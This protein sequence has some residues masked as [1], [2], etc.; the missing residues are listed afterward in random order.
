MK[1]KIVVPQKIDKPYT[2]WQVN[3]PAAM[4]GTR[5]VRKFFATK[6]EADSFI[7]RTLSR[8]WDGAEV[9]PRARAGGPEDSH[10][11]EGMRIDELIHVYLSRQESR[12]GKT[13]MRQL[14]YIFKSL[15]KSMGN[16]TVKKVTH[17][18]IDDWLNTIPEGSTRWN[19][20]RIARRL[21]EHAINWLEVVE[22]N[23]LK[24]I[25]PPP[26]SSAEGGKGIDVL[27]PEQMSSCIKEA[28]AFPE[29]ERTRLLAWLALGGFAGLRT[30]EILNS[31]W[32]DVDL[33]AGEIYVRQPKRVRGWHP[34]YVKILP[35]ARRLFEKCNRP[36]ALELDTNA[37]TRADA[38][39]HGEG[40]RF[41]LN[42]QKILPGGQRTLYLLRRELM[43]RMGWKKWPQNCLRH[44]YGTYHLA[45]WE[46]LAKLRGQMGHESEGITRRHYATAA[47]GV[48]AAA[49]WAIGP[50][51]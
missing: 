48:D 8:G 50:K 47:R 26:K 7:A 32:Q 1:S 5:R 43:N 24:R 40:G 20:Y 15:S 23:P 11:D 49:W 4:T 12:V 33:K 38:R 9:R 51:A 45:R 18:H 3:F 10:A 17:V 35:A 41:V 14:R 29:P 28:G 31:H 42:T 46:N 21:W 13:M 19:H 27:T 37:P 44:S 34:R 25:E 16:R 30:E 39:E 2:P 6:E 22:R 36:E